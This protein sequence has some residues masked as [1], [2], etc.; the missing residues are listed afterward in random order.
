MASH[1]LLLVLYALLVSVAFAALL[2]DDPRA[3]V[4]LGG[5]MLAAFV[6]FAYVVGWLMYPLPL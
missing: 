2:R 1:F 4:R 5:M 3:Q 6:A